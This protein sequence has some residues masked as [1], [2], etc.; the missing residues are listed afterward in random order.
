MCVEYVGN[1]GKTCFM[2]ANNNSLRSH[3]E[4]FVWTCFKKV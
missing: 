2:F 4:T 1:I 3:L